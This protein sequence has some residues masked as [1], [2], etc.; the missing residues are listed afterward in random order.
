MTELLLRESYLVPRTGT[1][2][3]SN[4]RQVVESW[5]MVA[6][7]EVGLCPLNGGNVLKQLKILGRWLHHSPEEL[8]AKSARSSTS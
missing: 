7:M 6:Y 4:S 2:M 8:Q 3:K 1:L 5:N